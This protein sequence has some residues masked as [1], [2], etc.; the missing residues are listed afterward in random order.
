MQPSGEPRSAPLSRRAFLRGSASAGFLAACLRC[1]GASASGTEIETP[2]ATALQAC[3]LVEIPT[4]AKKFNP[5][6]KITAANGAVGYTRVLNHTR[7]LSVA[8]AAV[9][10]LNL[11]DHRG[12]YDAMVRAGVPRLQLAI[13]DIAAWD[14]HARFLGRPLHALLGTKRTRI[15]RYGDVR[16]TQPGFSPTKYAREVA[17][18]LE[19]T[20]L[21][22]VKLHFPGAM[23]TPQSITL[24][25]VFATLREV[26]AAVGRDAILAWDPYPGSAESATPS[27]A[28]AKEILRLMD[29]LGYAWIEG[30]LPPTPFS[31]QIPRYAELV[32]SGVRLR[33]QAEGPGTSSDEGKSTDEGGA[34]GD[35]TAHAD[36]V[37]WHA[38]GAITQCSTDVYI[39]GGI[40]HALRMLEYAR[41]HPGLAIN[42]HWSWAPH[43][44]L[45]MAYD[46][47]VFPLGEFPMGEDFPRRLMDGPWLLAP[48]WPG[49]YHVE[50]S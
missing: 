38:A 23:G 1:P 33:I 24:P 42:L 22:A 27:L 3:E 32:R 49:V 48:Y 43:A 29:E 5:A 9:A 21:R 26:R 31:F 35:G 19:R 40:T 46:E 12:L 7:D 6:M 20:G 39:N 34:M 4:F 44:H 16:G 37:R 50:F 15:L 45:A 11:F 17:R 2:A 18:Y 28:E 47:S 25:E 41:A 13:L 8:R 10:G 14:L 30:P 36:M